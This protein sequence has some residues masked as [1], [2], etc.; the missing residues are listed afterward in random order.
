MSETPPQKRRH[1][2]SDTGPSAVA[3]PSVPEQQSAPDPHRPAPVASFED[4]P[5][6]VLPMIPRQRT[7]R[8]GPPP[9]ARR[10]E[11]LRPAPAPVTRPPGGLRLPELPQSVRPVLPAVLGAA[12]ALVL[13]LGVVAGVNGAPAPAPAPPAPAATP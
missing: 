12:T 3:W 7:G 9:V 1:A 4:A 8:S 2:L 6:Q 13:A 5:T 11:P 10:P